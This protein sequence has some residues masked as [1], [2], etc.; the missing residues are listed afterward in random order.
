MSQNIEQRAAKALLER[1]VK[2]SLTA[3]AILRLIGKKTV[4][5]TVRQPTLG[6]LY[7]IAEVYLS[8]GIEVDSLD[9]MNMDQGYKLVSQHGKKMCEIAA[10]SI[11]NN[12]L[13][14]RYFLKPLARLLFKRATPS[15][16]YTIF[17]AIVVFGGVA[18][19]SNT[20]RLIS[21]MRV[22]MPRNLSQNS[23]GS[24]DPSLSIALGDLNTP[25]PAPPAGP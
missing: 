22:T 19:F 6:N 8:M 17:Y 20:I 14:G 10:H 13:L 21:T 12:Y 3:P 5:F 11:L 18:D 23:Q 16:I 25:S 9:N 1:G 15:E 4:G 2:I 7:R 24:Y